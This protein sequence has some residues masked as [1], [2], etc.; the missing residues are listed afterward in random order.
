MGWP[1]RSDD[2]EETLDILR[3]GFRVHAVS[4][5]WIHQRFAEIQDNFL[6]GR[7]A[8][9]F[10]GQTVL[11]EKIILTVCV[12]IALTV[13]SLTTGSKRLQCTWL[14]LQWLTVS[15]NRESEAWQACLLWL[16]LN[17]WRCHCQ[18]TNLTWWA[19]LGAGNHWMEFSYCVKI[20]FRVGI[21][22]L[23][24]RGHISTKHN[25]SDSSWV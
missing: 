24:V 2:P 11:K 14:P 15:L 25:T 9:D 13:Y 20:F 4:L 16:D 10:V 1:S 6:F 8:T 3:R 22:P 5:A 7:S 17:L 21:A 18:D 19:I 12:R 23:E